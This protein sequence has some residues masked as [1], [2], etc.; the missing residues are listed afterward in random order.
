M[1]AI[2]AIACLLCAVVPVGGMCQTA[3]ELLTPPSTSSTVEILGPDESIEVG[4]LIRLRATGIATEYS[5]VVVP[6]T[7]DFEAIGDRAF[8]SARGPGQFTIILAVAT[9][10]GIEQVTHVVTVGEGPAPSPFP[11]PRPTPGPKTTRLQVAIVENSDDRTPE[12]A[13]VYVTGLKLIAW[14]KDNGHPRI[15]LL[16]TPSAQTDVAPWTAR[17]GDRIP[18]VF[19]IDDASRV[20]HEGKLPQTEAEMLELVKRYGAEKCPT[21]SGSKP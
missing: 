17:A 7:E 11:S 21:V 13:A 19:L 4:E 18:Y 15:R 9:A 20:V 5:W 3:G 16:E 2:S 14:L 8:L 6:P 10:D 1:K 12:Q